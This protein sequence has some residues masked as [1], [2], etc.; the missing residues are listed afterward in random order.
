MQVN[1]VPV[2]HIN[3]VY[4]TETVSKGW[5]HL[6]GTHLFTKCCLSHPQPCL[7]SLKKNILES[8]EK[9]TV[10]V[11]DA[12]LPAKHF[13][14]RR[15]S[16]AG[17]GAMYTNRPQ[18]SPVIYCLVSPHDATPSLYSVLET[19]CKMETWKQCSVVCIIFIVH[20]KGWVLPE[21]LQTPAFW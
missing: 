4:M 1:K 15:L 14:V 13:G 16:A 12:L 17:T 11:S 10:T 9:H 5:R 6:A 3:P 20:K 18:N 7:S 19:I 2:L 21:M 8:T